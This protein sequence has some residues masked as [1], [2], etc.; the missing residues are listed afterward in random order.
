MSSRRQAVGSRKYV[1]MSDELKCIS[2]HTE[3][4][5]SIGWD[6]HCEKVVTRFGTRLGQQGV[7]G[8]PLLPGH[9]RRGVE[10]AESSRR[11]RL[12]LAD[13]Q[14][15]MGLP[16]GIPP[17]SLLTALY[18]LLTTPYSLILS[19]PYSPLT[20]HYYSRLPTHYSLLP[21]PCSL[22]T[23]HHSPLTTHR[24]LLTTPHSVF[25]TP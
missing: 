19:T 10:G 3:L 5:T 20:T 16:A 12:L 13:S 8:A 25:S 23:T 11:P 21:T 7:C 18:S 6:R 17:Y 4:C 24:S 2:G 9:P 1:M 22:L 14:H 15:G